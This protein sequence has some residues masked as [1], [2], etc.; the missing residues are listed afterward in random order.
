[1]LGDYIEWAEGYGKRFQI[2][3]SDYETQKRIPKLSAQWYAEVIRQ[4]RV[5]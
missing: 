5:V 3:Y 4:N 1:V 2:V